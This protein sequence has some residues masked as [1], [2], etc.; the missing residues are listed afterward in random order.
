[1][2]L[3]R[4]KEAFVA[5]F[6]RSQRGNLWRHWAGG[7]CGQLILTVFLRRDGFYYYVIADGG[8]PAF[9]T[10]GYGTEQEAV[11]ALWQ[12]LSASPSA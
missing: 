5:G 6:Q 9:S 11:E 7:D 2:T 3:I 10:R 12:E 8:R 1:M 4:T